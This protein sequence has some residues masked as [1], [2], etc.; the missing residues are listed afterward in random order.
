MI[1][2]LSL[3]LSSLLGLGLLLN[4]LGSLLGLLIFIIFII[5]IFVIIILVIILRTLL[6]LAC[7]GL[8][9]WSDCFLGSLFLGDDSSEE[10]G[11]NEKDDYDF[12]EKI[13][14]R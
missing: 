13:H 5:V 11:E 8:L 2:F 7:G 9:G 4:F 6:A 12:V 3:S 10:A 14:S 1:S